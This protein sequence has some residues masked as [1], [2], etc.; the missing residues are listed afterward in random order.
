MKRMTA[1]DNE[2]RQLLVVRGNLDKTENAI[3]KCKPVLSFVAVNSSRLVAWAPRRR[4]S[5]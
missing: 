3:T 5:T 2:E 4:Y 1:D